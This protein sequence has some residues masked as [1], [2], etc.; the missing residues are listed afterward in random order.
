MQLVD[1]I[2][3]GDDDSQ[4]KLA[5]S[6]V[7]LLRRGITFDDD[8]PVLQPTGACCSVVIDLL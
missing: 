3:L 5:L 1:E 6:E 4:E 8:L 7:D 2:R